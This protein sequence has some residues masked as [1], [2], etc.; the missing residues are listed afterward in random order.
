MATLSNGELKKYR[1]LPFKN[2]EG[3]R[4]ET[5]LHYIENKKP[6]TCSPKGA[7]KVGSTTV[8]L[9]D[10]DNLS[11]K[12]R[13]AIHSQNFSKLSNIKLTTESGQQIVLSDLEK[14]EDFGKSGGMGGGTEQT[15][16][17]E[18]A[19][20]IVCGA[21]S[22]GHQIRTELPEG[23]YS[24]PDADRVW[25][26]YLHLSEE[27]QKAT[28]ETAKALVSYLGEEKWIF[29]YNDDL[30]QS[31]LQKFNELKKGHFSGKKDKWNPADIW[32]SRGDVDVS[33]FTDFDEFSKFCF[34]DNLK[35]ISLKK[36]G[37][38]IKECPDVKAKFAVENAK[39]VSSPENKAHQLKWSFNFSEQDKE[40]N[41]TVR[42]DRMHLKAEIKTKGSNHRNGSC[43]QEFISQVY[44]SLGFGEINLKSEF[45]ELER[46]QKQDILDHPG[47]YSEDRWL[48]AEQDNLDYSVNSE[49]EY[50]PGLSKM[51]PKD[52]ENLAVDQVLNRM[53]ENLQGEHL[54]N[55]ISQ[56]SRY[57]VSALK[58]SCR[59][60]K[61][62]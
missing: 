49:G 54:K 20:C 9:R 13:E 42:P 17:I 27:W 6:F 33:G 50:I 61:V 43:G 19:Q 46:I 38:K 22:T 15:A 3:F 1:F 51:S 39:L 8:V 7:E 47:D 59:Y 58:N 5:F 34:S 29:R 37:T 44:S 32:I 30:V 35:G 62:S 52:L 21:L 41:L 60:L 57:C 23:A 56:I 4:W 12:I 45:Q 16:I 31:I 11:Q 55:F 14:T 36:G 40:K 25:D 28:E 2:D 18:A 10:Q 24:V 53:K 26:A 48:G